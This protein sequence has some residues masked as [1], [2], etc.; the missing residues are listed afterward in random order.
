MKKNTFYFYWVLF[1]IFG[2]IP[3]G[4]FKEAENSIVYDYVFEH[5][6]HLIIISFGFSIYYKELIN[7]NNSENKTKRILENIWAV[8]LGTIL[9][10][11]GNIA[12]F[13]GVILIINSN[14]GEQKTIKVDVGIVDVQPIKRRSGR[15]VGYE[16]ETEKIP[17]LGRELKMEMGINQYKE[18]KDRRYQAELKVGSLGIVYKSNKIKKDDK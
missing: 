11:I 6:V 9:F 18:I 16:I 10:I 2:I 17:E 4:A 5:K 3:F 1:F 12:L 15:T 7:T 8:L 13:A 14:F